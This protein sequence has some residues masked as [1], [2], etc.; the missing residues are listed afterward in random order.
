MRTSIKKNT[1]SNRKEM[2]TFIYEN[3]PNNALLFAWEER[4][5]YEDKEEEIGKPN[6]PI[7]VDWVL[8]AIDEGGDTECYD[9]W[10]EEIIYSFLHSNNTREKIGE[11]KVANLDW[12][13]MIDTEWE[14]YINEILTE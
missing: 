7:L 8:T 5:E 4:C 14:D 11:E 12:V 6:I 1:P 2:L 3:M 13:R 10:E 9:E